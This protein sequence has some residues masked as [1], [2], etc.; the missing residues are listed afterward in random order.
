MAYYLLAAEADQIQDFVFRASRLREVA[1]GSQLLSRFCKEGAVELLKKHGGN[2]AQDIIINDGGAFRILFSDQQK[3]KD[4]GRD[5]A[6]L[7]RRV[8][9]GNLTVADPVAY[10]GDFQAASE[11]VHENLRDAKSQGDVPAAA[12]HLPYLAFC[13]SCGIA[14]AIDHRHRFP[15][16]PTDRPNYVCAECRRKAAEPHVQRDSF[17]GAFRKAVRGHLPRQLRRHPLR[18]PEK[19][20][21]AD[22][23][24]Q[25]DSRRYLAYLLADGNGMGALFSA[26]DSPEKMHALSIALTEILRYSLAA[27]SAQLIEHQDIV[28]RKAFLPILPLILSG[29]DVFALLPAPWAIDFAARFCLEYEQRMKQKL[30]ELSLLEGG[31]VPTVAAAVVICKA[32]Y[33]HRLAHRIGKNLLHEAKQLA[34]GLE[35]HP[36]ATKRAQVSVLNFT[37]ITGNEVGNPERPE[38]ARYHPT[39][40]PYF[41]REDLDDRVKPVGIPIRRLLKHRLS[42]S[43]AEL[44]GKRRAEFERLYDRAIKDDNQLKDEWK[45]AFDVL[46]KRIERMKKSLRQACEEALSELGEASQKDIGYWR[47]FER[48]LGQGFHGHGLPDLLTIWNYAY[49]LEKDLSEYEE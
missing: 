25:L 3:A 38:S 17:I 44:P 43:K 30:Q 14:P 31:K 27:P 29:D 7:Y 4:F 40:R 35:T 12:V 18:S 19:G 24:S 23:I 39:G 16:D 22:A 6:E 48:P 42:L 37:L 49:D 26:C 36:D 13:A 2:P 47:F 41:A 1:G 8:A 28:R 11:Q 34:R 9:G 21:W 15:M 5:L 10:S 46:L 20:D 32:N 45:P 33:P